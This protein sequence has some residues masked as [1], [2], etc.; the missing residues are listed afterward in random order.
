MTFA[1]AL[2]LSGA[3]YAW[4][5]D[6]GIVTQGVPGWL[7]DL[8][9]GLGVQLVIRRR[10]GR[11]RGAHRAPPRLWWAALAV[12]VGAFVYLMSLLSPLVLEPLFQRTEPLRDPALAPRSST[13]P[14]GPA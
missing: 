13:W 8:A 2:P 9:K 5:R 12:I 3:R 6:Y 10:S 14:T 11:G 4:G 7:I 1:V